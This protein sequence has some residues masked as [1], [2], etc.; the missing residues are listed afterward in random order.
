MASMGFL[1]QV[2]TWIDWGRRVQFLI[3]IGGILWSFCVGATMRAVLVS[4]THVPAIW[5]L[6]IYLAAS[7]MA[8]IVYVL[9]SQWWTAKRKRS[10]T[11]EVEE[12]IR[13]IKIEGARWILFDFFADKAAELLRD[14]ESLWHHWD[15]VGEKLIH[16]LDAT[17]DKIEFSKEHF[18]KL[19]NERRDFQTLYI[20]HVQTLKTVFPDF[21][22]WVVNT[23]FPSDAEY[24]DV[25]AQLK[26]HAGKLKT[27]SKT[28]WKKY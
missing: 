15:N 12:T 17:K 2:K 9:A 18:Y 28:A 11:A 25:L 4:F 13:K 1:D 5:H 21:A 26:A 19:N 23:G 3:T 14:L 24:H 10:S 6:P 22:S 16:P 20:A 27:E 7:L 8:L